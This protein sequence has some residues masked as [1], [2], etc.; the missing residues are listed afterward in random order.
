MQPF[1]QNND[2]LEVAPLAG[3]RI[4]C[5]DVLL[6][7]ACKGRLLAHRVVKMDRRN[8]ISQYLIK[9]DAGASPDGWFQLENILGWVEV[10]ERGC[11]RIKLTSGAQKFRSRVWVMISPWVS[12]FSWLP[13]RFRQGVWN[14]L[15]VS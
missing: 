1:I 13:D 7:E 11:Q 14:W 2:I 6:V 4:K 3:K 8:G 9:S 12:K 10:V 15:L 5:G